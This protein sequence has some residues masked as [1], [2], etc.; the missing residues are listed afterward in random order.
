MHLAFF[1]HQGSICPF[2]GE[3][4]TLFLPSL[5]QLR[6]FLQDMLMSNRALSHTGCREPVNFICWLYF[7]YS[8]IHVKLTFYFIG[9]L[10]VL[11]IWEVENRNGEGNGKMK[12]CIC[13]LLSSHS[14]CWVPGSVMLLADVTCFEASFQGI[15]P[16]ILMVSQPFERFSITCILSVLHKGRENNKRVKST[17]YLISTFCSRISI[18]YQMSFTGL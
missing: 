15:L 7:G 17:Q 3:Q 9:C 12:V 1:S 11:V 18:T 2:F 16:E 8:G 13:C 4:F 5:T 14:K 6:V 10:L